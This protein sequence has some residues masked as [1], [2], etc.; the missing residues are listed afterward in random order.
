MN[1][2]SMVELHGYKIFVSIWHPGHIR[3]R[4]CS[5]KGGGA[6]APMAPSLNTSLLQVQRR[7][8]GWGMATKAM[9]PP[10]AFAF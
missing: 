10:M 7:T 8:G 6:M 3:I 9:E 1:I 2:K 4:L 5:L